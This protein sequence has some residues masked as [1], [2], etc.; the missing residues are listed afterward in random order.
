MYAEILPEQY[1]IL[2]D[3]HK[4]T[5]YNKVMASYADS[6]LYLGIAQ[7]STLLLCNSYQAQDFTTA[8]YYLFAALSKFQLNPEVTTIWFRTPLTDEQELSLYNYF[9]L[10]EKI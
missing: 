8:E 6:R 2:R 5:D 3:M 10:V 7:G 4:L 1:C 9:K